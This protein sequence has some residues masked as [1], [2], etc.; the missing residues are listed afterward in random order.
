MP[1][2][3][4]GDDSL[5]GSAG[6]D[7]ILAGGG[8]DY[9]HSY[10]MADASLGQ[11]DG[12]MEVQ[13][14]A[15]ILSGGTGNDTVLSGGGND[16]VYGDYGTDFIDAGTG[17]DVMSGGLG[18]DI[19]SFKSVMTTPG[20]FAYSGTDRIT[21]FR[22][23]EDLIDLRGYSADYYGTHGVVFLGEGG[24]LART[25]QAMAA[26]RY[27][28][29]TTVIEVMAGHSYDTTSAVSAQIVLNGHVALTAGDFLLA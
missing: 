10:A 24:A 27:E 18:A 14:G 8:N 3:T 4:N 12:M 2:S 23:G 11:T 22:A 7:R 5:I 26:F 21:D 25:D 9:V 16:T 17:N 1:I 29:N 15:D 20:S 28:G 13:D 6:Y 19:F